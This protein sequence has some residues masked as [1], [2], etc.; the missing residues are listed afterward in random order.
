M[1]TKSHA[2]KGAQ[3]VRI[4]REFHNPRIVEALRH[5]DEDTL[6]EILDDSEV[7]DALKHAKKEN[8]PVRPAGEFIKELRDEKLI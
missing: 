3:A 6:A 5:V 1:M 7:L 4:D 8:E 2:E